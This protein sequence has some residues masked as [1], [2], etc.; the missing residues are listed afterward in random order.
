MLEDRIAGG[1]VEAAIGERQR[2][3][4]D[5]LPVS[6]LRECGLELARGPEPDCSDPFEMWVFALKHVGSV[7]YY[8]GDA[9]IEDGAGGGWARKK[10]EIPI[11][12]V[13]GNHY[14]P[15]GQRGWFRDLIVTLIDLLVFGGVRLRFALS[16]RA[17]SMGGSLV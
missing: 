13:T 14:H 17:T 16:Q 3:A 11:N 1:D 10:Y 2:L 9:D 7:A 12:A 6:N 5:N 4:G 8:V 15:L